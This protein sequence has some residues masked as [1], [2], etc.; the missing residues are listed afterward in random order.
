MAAPGD[1]FLFV[2]CYD[3]GDESAQVWAFTAVPSNS[4]GAD[5]DMGIIVNGASSKLQQKIGGT[6]TDVAGSGGSVSSVF[7]RTGAVVATAGDYTSTLVTNSSTV[8]GATVTAALDQL[9]SQAV[10]T[11]GTAG[12][13]LRK[14]SGTNY[15]DAWATIASGEVTNSSTVSGATVTAALDQ[16]A[17]QAVPT[18][19]TAGQFL[20][21]ASGTNYDDAWATPTSTEVTNSST[22]VGATVTAA[23]N[24]LDGRGYLPTGGAKGDLVWKQSGTNYDVAYTA[25]PQ[26]TNQ[27]TNPAAADAGYTRVHIRQAGLPWLASTSSIGGTVMYEQMHGTVSKVTIRPSTGTA[28]TTQG[29]TVTS[30]GTLSHPAADNTYGWMT[31]FASSAALN[32]TAGTGNADVMWRRG[33]ASTNAAG[34]FFKCRFAPPDASYNEA[35][36]TTGSR[37][38]VGLTSGTMASMV[39]A[40]TPAGDYAGFH[41]CHVNGGQQH[42]TFRFKMRDNVTTSDAD[43]GMTFTVQNVYVAYIYCFAG[44]STVY[45]RIDNITAGTTAAGS[46]SSNP[47]RTT[48]NMR[49]GLQVGTVNATARNIRMA[50]IDCQESR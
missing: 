43:T 34:F 33:A 3:D 44:D 8:S 5:G 37:I 47:P 10:P 41:R 30:V 40:D 48:I 15:D 50:M 38:W 29:N 31:N 22:V 6:W 24:T 2:R 16:L 11:G 13:Y 19:G 39:T 25:T 9:V 1:T 7:G 35:G 20:R 27:T 42:T 12:Q 36:A 45:W 21:K 14:A 17:S 18:G 32:A 23:L 4:L 46:T 49:C 26:L 28:V